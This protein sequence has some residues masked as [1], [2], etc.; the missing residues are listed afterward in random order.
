MVTARWSRVSLW[1]GMRE[2]EKGGHPMAA[3][4][5]ALAG[6]GGEGKEGRSPHGRSWAPRTPWASRERRGKD[7]PLT[8]GGGT[9]GAAAA[10]PYVILYISEQFSMRFIHSALKAKSSEL[11]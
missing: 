4:S 11:I 5:T 3:P 9:A 7:E 8:S 6:D 10:T 2:Q 1:Q